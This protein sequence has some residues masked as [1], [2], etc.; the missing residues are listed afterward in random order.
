MLTFDDGYRDF[1]EDAW[2]LLERHG[3]RATLF[4]VTDAAGDASRWD[5]S[6]GRPADLLG[7]DEIEELHGRGLHV[8]SHTASHPWLTGLSNADAVRELLRSR[9]ALED[10]LGTA[11]SSI[12]YPYGDVDGALAR[13]AGACGYTLGF[14]CEARHAE[15]TDA[16][17]LFPRFEVRGEFTIEDFARTL[18]P[19]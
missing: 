8:G 16:A 10:R 14:T 2:P 6:H 17:L 5:A 13:L 15:L 18:A 11:V 9:T 3:F 12:A 19:E 7:W 1:A 4:V